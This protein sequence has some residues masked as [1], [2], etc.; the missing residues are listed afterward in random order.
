M[1]INVS[2]FRK[3]VCATVCENKHTYVCP[4]PSVNPKLNVILVHENF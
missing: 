1:N 4:H 2:R 3:H